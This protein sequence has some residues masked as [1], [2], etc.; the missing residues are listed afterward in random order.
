MIICIVIK[1]YFISTINS[2]DKVFYCS[3]ECRNEAWNR[4][5]KFI[6]LR[7][8]LK[9]DEE[10]KEKN[11]DDDNDN[12]QNNESKSNEIEINPLLELEVYSLK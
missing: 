11:N 4:Y 7:N 2:C 1:S 3:N 10:K 9:V 5:H 12:N 6:C 8:V